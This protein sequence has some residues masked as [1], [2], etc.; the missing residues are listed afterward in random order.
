MTTPAARFTLRQLPLPAKLVVSAFLLAVGVGYTS[1][2][3]QLHM[4]HGERDGTHLPTPNDVVAVFAGKVWKTDGDPQ[5][6]SRLEQI[7]IG[8]S[9]GGINSRNMAPAFFADDEADY[10]KQAADP[11]RKPRLDA[12]REGERGAVVAWANAPDEARQKAYDANEFVLPPDRAKAPVSDAYLNKAKP[13]TVLIK[14]ILRDRC[15]RC[16]QPGGDKGDVPLTT[17]RELA[18]Y[19]SNEVPVPEGGGW[20]DSGRKMSLEKLTQST[21]AHLLSFAVL[22][23][24]TGLAFAFTGFPG[25]VRGFFGPLVLVAQFADVSCWWLA[26]LPE[27]GPYFALC[28]I[29]TGMAVGVGLG[30]QIVGSLFSM[31]GPKGKAV[32]AAMY[33]LAGGVG[34]LLYVNVV[35]PHLEDEKKA[36]AAKA[37]EK[38]PAEQGNGA[39]PATGPSRLERLL[40]GEYNPKGPFN[41][42]KD[43]GMV[44]AFFNKD[45]AFGDEQVEA[46][47]G[48]QG[49]VLAWLKADPAARKA[50]YEADRFPL[51]A[52]LVGKPLTAEFFADAKAVKVKSLFAARCATCHNPDGDQGKYPLTSFEQIEKYLKPEPA[53]PAN[54]EAGKAAEPIPPAEE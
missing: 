18:K 45:D 20:V 37:A 52:E 50:A 48:D 22:F 39:G 41:G 38:K 13:G 15:A 51:P 8:P 42:K 19:L 34:V 23:G 44:R 49:A 54:G 3:V 17:Y 32:L 6:K 24:L 25:Y 43:G 1:A 33:L 7:I 5:M 2:M 11:A 46:R 21:H 16:H 53:A 14:Y 12:E 40:T 4:Q 30:V 27:N 10:R 9:T 31:Y 28:I 36:K 29:G 47:K 35:G 26:R